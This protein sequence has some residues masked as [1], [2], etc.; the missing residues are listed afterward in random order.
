[1]SDMAGEGGGDGADGG[2]GGRRVI[3]LW[4][5]I[6]AHISPATSRL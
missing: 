6:V 4:G 1:M 5:G 2:T 3:Y